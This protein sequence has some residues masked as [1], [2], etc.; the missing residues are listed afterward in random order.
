MLKAMMGRRRSGIEIVHAILSLCNDSDANRTA[1]MYRCNLSYAQLCRYLHQLSVRNLVRKN[2][3][4]YFVLTSTGRETL[5]KVT[6][7]I[8]TLRDL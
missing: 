2:K 5:G 1:I 4:G 7:I 3:A 6:V 8:S